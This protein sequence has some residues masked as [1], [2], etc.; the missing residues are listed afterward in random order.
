MGCSPRSHKESD[1]TEANEHAYDET[2][3]IIK[4]SR[5]DYR[6]VRV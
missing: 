2:N 3:N 4:Q 1:T 5:K 6:V